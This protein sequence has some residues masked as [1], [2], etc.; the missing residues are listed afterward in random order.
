VTIR[1]A[2]L[3]VA[4]TLIAGCSSNPSSPAPSSGAIDSRHVV[5]DTDMGAGDVVALLYLLRAPSVTVDAVVVSGTGLSHC[6]PGAAHARALVALAN[7]AAPVTCGAD[8]PLAGDR[9][10]PAARRAA[11]DDLYGVKVPAGPAA[12]ASH[13]ARAAT[14][15]AAI[16]AAGDG[17]TVVNLAP[18]TDLAGA[19]QAD[20]SAASSIDMVYLMGGAF[21]VDGDVGA[22]PGAEWNLYVD[23]LADQEVLRSGV[24][25]TFVPLDAAADVPLT[26]ELVDALGAGGDP[27]GTTAGKVLA[28]QF[29]PRSVDLGDPTAAVIAV[30]GAAGS[31]VNGVISIDPASGATVRDEYGVRVRVVTDADP[32]AVGSALESALTADPG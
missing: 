2:V 12:P 5:I 20:P 9:T 21:D 10:F 8:T 25:L 19:F 4:A 23:P 14:L 31:I 17:V 27:V 29:A 3:A 1:R 15:A 30:D 24:P 26:R 11:A 13:V 7:S 28:T 16:S 22:A 6:G 18:L 32:D